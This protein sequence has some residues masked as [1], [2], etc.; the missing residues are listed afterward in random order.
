MARKDS[1]IT[2]FATILLVGHCQASS[3][4]IRGNANVLRF[5]ARQRFTAEDFTFDLEGAEPEIEGVGGTV[6]VSKLQGWR[7]MDKGL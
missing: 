3:S 1:V 2:A 7:A 6:K 4:D 5:G